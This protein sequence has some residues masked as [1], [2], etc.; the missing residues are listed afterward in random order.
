MSLL[1]VW[2]ITVEAGLD[3]V[4]AFTQAVWKNPLNVALAEFWHAALNKIEFFCN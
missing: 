4:F 2:L 1:K 3:F